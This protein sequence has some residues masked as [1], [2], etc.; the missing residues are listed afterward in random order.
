MV[1][2]EAKILFTVAGIA[3]GGLALWA[4]YVNVTVKKRWVFGPDDIASVPGA[5]LPQA[6]PSDTAAA[7]ALPAVSG[8]GTPSTDKSND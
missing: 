6:L 4:I 7:S 2:D 8:E 5:I 3:L 1:P